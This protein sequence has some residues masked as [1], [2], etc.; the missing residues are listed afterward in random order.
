LVRAV[1][2]KSLRVYSRNPAPEYVQA[3]HEA[4]EGWTRRQ[5][6]SRVLTST[7][8]KPPR[9]PPL[10]QAPAAA[11]AALA[12]GADAAGTKR[13]RDLF[14]SGNSDDDVSPSNLMKTKQMRQ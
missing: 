6:G 1:Q 2:E 5:F 13:S 4:F 10:G 12:G 11:L 8:A 3:L 9:P 7:P 14:P